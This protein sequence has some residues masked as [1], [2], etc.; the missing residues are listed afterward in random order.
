METL[1]YPLSPVF[2]GTE[3]PLCILGLLSNLCCLVYIVFKLKINMYIRR[4]LLM[5]TVFMV[6]MQSVN[7]ASLV[8][9]NVTKTVNVTSCALLIVPKMVKTLVSGHFSMAI[10]VVRYYLAKQTANVEAI[11]HMFLKWFVNSVFGLALT[12]VSV[13]V[14][15]ISLSDSMTVSPIVALC[16]KVDFE[17]EPTTAMVMATGIL[18]VFVGIFNDLRLARLMKERKKI[19][20]IQMVVWTTKGST[21][22]N[23]KD[24]SD[25]KMIVP[26]KATIIGMFFLVVFVLIMSLLQGV[27]MSKKLSS[28]GFLLINGFGS[29]FDFYMLLILSL[30]VKSNEKKTSHCQPSVPPMELQFHE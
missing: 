13:F 28:L 24:D 7:I 2:W 18:S 10:A 22:M 19:G 21:T 5:T 14:G 27:W 4:I 29:F 12:C 20:P 9:I 26:V 3:G 11:N 6:G 15:I 17:F 1:E 16:A 8:Y 30:T 25:S 23:N